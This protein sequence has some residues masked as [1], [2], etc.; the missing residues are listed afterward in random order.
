VNWHPSATPE[1]L[2]ARARL[3]HRL[4]AFFDAR[5]VL[6]VETPQLSSRSVTDP[7][8]E[9]LLV[10]SG[11]CVAGAR[12]LPP[13]PEFPMK[14]LLAAHAAPIYQ[15]TRA[16]RDGESGPRHSPEFTLLEWYRPGFDL[17][18][19]MDEVAELLRLCLGERAERSS[20]YRALFHQRLRLDPMTASARELEA[21]AR[22]HIEAGDLGGDRDLWLD[23]LMSHVIEPQL[24]GVWFVYDYPPSQAALARVE[25]RDGVEVARRFEVF[26]DGVELANGFHELADAREQRRRFEADNAR[27]R[28]RGQPERPIDERLL[29]A[30][31]HGLPDCCGVALGV[32][33]LLM[34]ITGATDIRDVLA[35]D[36]SRA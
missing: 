11:T 10:T 34:L 33:R 8:I 30:L 24:E 2:R 17:E 19:L 29:A 35:F 12:F 27:R 14:R 26:A 5:G 28:E 16:F 7:A 3:L 36:W 22:Q 1:V 25:T 9:P 21:V 6:E 32:D 31:E 15:V 20:S 23:L 18:T 13:S 4:R